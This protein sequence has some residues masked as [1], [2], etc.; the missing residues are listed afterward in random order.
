MSS[1]ERIKPDEWPVDTEVVGPSRDEDRRRERC[2]VGREALQV[3][4]EALQG[5]KA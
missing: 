4:L 1:E 5:L 2:S 3:N